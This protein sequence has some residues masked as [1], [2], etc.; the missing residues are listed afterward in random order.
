MLGGSEKGG[1]FWSVESVVLDVPWAE[2]VFP[3]EALAA[4]PC[5]ALLAVT[6][7]LFARGLGRAFSVVPD[8]DFPVIK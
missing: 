4:L 2:L 1:G 6:A 3:A 5:P 8:R 7:W